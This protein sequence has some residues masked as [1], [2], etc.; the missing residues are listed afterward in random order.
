MQY[1]ICSVQ[2]AVCAACDLRLACKSTCSKALSWNGGSLAAVYSEYS[3]VY[4][5]YSTV[6]SEHST[7]YREYST[8]YSEYSTS[9]RKA[10][11]QL[12]SLAPWDRSGVGDLQF[13]VCRMQ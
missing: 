2:Y 1:A 5:E 7:V 6:Y 13:G 8:V 4:S 12:R 11:V 3:T 9:R 10:D